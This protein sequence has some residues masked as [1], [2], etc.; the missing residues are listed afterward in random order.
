MAMTGLLVESWPMTPGADIA[1][2]VIKAGPNAVSPLG[3]EF[4][5]GDGVFSCSR[6]GMKGYAPWAEKV[7]STP[8]PSHS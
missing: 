4:K 8:S 2:V 1:G 5:E 3:K 6:L 7:R